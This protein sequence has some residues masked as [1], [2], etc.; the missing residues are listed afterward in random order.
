[1][2]ELIVERKRKFLQKFCLCENIICQVL[3]VMATDELSL[4]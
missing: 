1:V 4:L 3:A 2:S